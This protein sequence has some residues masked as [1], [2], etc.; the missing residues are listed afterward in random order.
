MEPRF[1]SEQDR[2]TRVFENERNSLGRAVRIERNV[3]A[4]GFQHSQNSDDHLDRALDAHAYPELRTDSQSL[5]LLRQLVRAMI[6]LSVCQAPA[7]EGDCRRFGSAAG[8]ALE[9]MV[10]AFSDGDARDSLLDEPAAF[11]R[12][13]QR[14]LSDRAVRRRRNRFQQRTQMA[15]H[16]SHRFAVEK[17]RAVFE[18][19][20]QSFGRFREIKRQIELRGTR[21]EIH[22]ANGQTRKTGEIGS[23]CL[24]HEDRLEQRRVRR[25]AARLELVH[26]LFKRQVLM[27]ERA[28][29]RFPNL[30][31]QFAKTHFAG[32]PRAQRQHVYKEAYEMLDLCAIAIGNGRSDDKVLLARVAEEQHLK[33][34][35]QQHEQGG[36]FALGQSF[37]GMR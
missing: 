16:A 20:F 30:R 2:R 4:S 25:I 11:L 29:R 12:I 32:E 21:F 35:Q 5:Q 23:G 31:Q 19:A 3:S 37:Q 14:Q 18:P 22:D 17:L 10:D 27:R 13:Q 7:L 6:Q 33:S 26:E 36:A 34:R 15:L 8:D 1:L 9:P 24:E 28:E